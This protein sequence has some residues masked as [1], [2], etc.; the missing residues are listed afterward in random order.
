MNP[1]LLCVL[2]LA[3]VSPP[4]HPLLLVLVVHHLVLLGLGGD[5]LGRRERLP[6]R[7]RGELGEGLL[8][9]ETGRDRGEVGD[10]TLLDDA[11]RLGP[12]LVDEEL[13][14]VAGVGEED[15][16]LVLPT[17]RRKNVSRRR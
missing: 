7:H 16:L 11:G 12:D 1:L 3:L 10:D 4:R 5:P 17:R 8:T 13:D 15:L 14:A 6:L 9:G 2:V